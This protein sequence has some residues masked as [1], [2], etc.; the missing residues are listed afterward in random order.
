MNE[1]DLW[2][3]MILD[4]AALGRE[5]LDALISSG[6]VR[7]VHD[8][9][10]AQL[11]DLAATREP[12]HELSDV[13]LDERVSRLLGGTPVD[14]YGRWVHY[15]WSGEL[16]HLLGPDE[17][18]ELRLDR[19]RN[20][21]MPAEAARLRELT[22]GIVGLS[23]G[24]AV[25]LTLAL[26]GS[27][28]HIRLAD[29]DRL[30]LSNMNRVRASVADVGLRKTVLAARQMLEVDPYLDISVMHEGV[31]ANSV[32]RFL[33]GDGEL[34]PPLDVVVD[35]CDSI[36]VKFLLREHARGRRLPVLMETSDRGMLDVER[37][38]LEPDRPLFHGRAGELSSTDV[39]E[40]EQSPLASEYKARTAVRI[41]D[42]AH[43][44]ARLAAS[45]AEIDKSLSSWPQLASDVLLG[46][47]SVA[48]AVR[49]LALGLPL[50][51]G[52]RYIDLQKT[53]TPAAADEAPRE[54]PLLPSLGAAH[55]DRVD[56]VP[57]HVRRIVELATRAPS[58]G[59]TQPWHFWWD[60]GRLWIT[61]DAARSRALLDCRGH[62]AALAL[63][64]A[65]ES[66]IIAAAV[67]GLVANVEMYPRPGDATIAA[68]IDLVEGDA[69]DLR[70]LAPELARRATD[71]RLAEALPLDP[72]AAAAL[73]EAAAC[74]D[75]GLQLVEDREGLTEI[76][77]IIGIS[78]RVRMLV[79]G[80]HA[81][82]V[83]ELRWNAVQ[84]QERGDGVTV[85]SLELGPG[86][87]AAI[88]LI[89][90]PE[91][92]ALLRKWDGAAALEDAA[93][94]S[95]A[96]ASAAG[97]LWIDR[98]DA[99]AWL[100][101]GRA[102]LRVWL[103]AGARGLALQPMTVVL[104]QV[105]MLTHTA[106]EIYTDNE[107]ATLQDLEQRLFT[108]F[109]PPSGGAALLFRLA[110][111]PGRPERSRRLPPAWVLSAGAPR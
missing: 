95:L 32:D 78:D 80:T 73:V 19:N 56:D 90:R 48:V 94:H 111:V 71:R 83:G 34:G 23:V 57:A 33:D 74:R 69:A 59:N 84:A 22:V 26:E 86:A 2:R 82:L 52:R 85:S 93:R 60:D 98:D 31:R 62:A 107:R 25:A 106:G 28:G 17:F 16:V 61:H 8:T 49:A 27:A 81:H 15:P 77:R 9:V 47:A 79:P 40:W 10:L 14:H 50:P 7:R 51:S 13:E 11:Q 18:R 100:A 20:K 30:A 3:P 76:G 65:V 44:S 42:P 102:L 108:V 104:Y 75:A 4:V 88:Q 64:A 99:N 58:G 37:F 103:E 54:M 53:I 12:D 110:R 41:I 38:D 92:A 87:Q 105:E 24:N 21:V 67:E 68:A 109:E 91:V 35:E 72:G 55:P 29:F 45:M 36:S 5:G 1:D 6:A 89:R 97:L 101:A 70:A 96:A 63:G 43:M 66:A 46:G 39:A